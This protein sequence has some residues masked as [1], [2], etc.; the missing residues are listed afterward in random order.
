MPPMMM[1][2][3][4]QQKQQHKK[5]MMRRTNHYANNNKH[6]VAGGAAAT[7]AAVVVAGGSARNNKNTNDNN[8]EALARVLVVRARFNPL[9][10]RALG[11]ARNALLLLQQQPGRAASLEEAA[12]ALREAAR[13]ESE[14]Q[15]AL[16]NNEEEKRAAAATRAIGTLQQHP[17]GKTFA[18]LAEEA[19][20]L[21]VSSS[22]RASSLL[23]AVSVL[24][25]DVYQA[26]F[27]CAMTMRLATAVY[28]AS[29]SSDA[30][31]HPSSSHQRE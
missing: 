14:F 26:E 30:H 23:L 29:S 22:A 19:S 13:L 4:R 12:E 1:M 27:G 6:S 20:S 17:L 7:A 21:V 9:A 8:D 5:T 3:T 2:I 10:A 18:E 11:R 28:F 15:R 25:D 31:H 24:A 16:E